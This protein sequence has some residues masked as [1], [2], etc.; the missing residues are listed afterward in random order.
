[1]NNN[2]KVCLKNNKI[3]DKNISRD[4]VIIQTTNIWELNMSSD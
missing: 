3:Y 1:M 2:V 4:L